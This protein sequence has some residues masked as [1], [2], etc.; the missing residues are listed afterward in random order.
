MAYLLHLECFVSFKE[1][2]VTSSLTFITNLKTYN[3]KT[4]IKLR[5]ILLVGLML[6]FRH[7]AF[8]QIPTSGMVAYYPFEGD[9]INALGSGFDATIISAEFTTN[10]EGINGSGLDFE[11]LDVTDYATTPM[12]NLGNSFSFNVWVKH[13]SLVDYG[14]ILGAADVKFGL[15][16]LSY[17]D[18]SIQA[19]LG[20]GSSWCSSTTETNYD[21]AKEGLWQMMTFTYDGEIIKLYVDG[22]LMLEHN[23]PG[24]SFNRPLIIGNRYD[25]HPAYGFDGI[26]DELRIY[27]RPLLETEIQSLANEFPI[28][29]P[30]Q[31]PLITMAGYPLDGN[32][33]DISGNGNDG[34]IFGAIP[35][36]DRYCNANMAMEFD[37]IDDYVSIPPEQI[38]TMSQGSIVGW[39]L[40]RDI[41]NNNC[42]FSIGNE[43][44]TNSKSN[45]MINPDGSVTFMLR[46][47]YSPP[48]YWHVSNP[49]MVLQDQWYHFALIQDPIFGFH[50]YLNGVELEFNIHPLGYELGT[51]FFDD[52]TTKPT[53][54]SLG[55]RKHHLYDQDYFN[56]VMDDIY[57][58]Q[59][60][61]SESEI[62]E[63]SGTGPWPAQCD[64]SPPEIIQPEE[65][66]QNTA[67]GFCY[68]NVILTEPIVY[69]DSEIASIINDAPELFQVGTTSVLWTATDVHDNSSSVVQNVTVIDN[70]KPEILAEGN[71]L[72]ENDPGTCS[73]IVAL[74]TPEVTDNCG[75]LSIENDAPVEF[76]VGLTTVTWIV[77]D[78]NENEN[79]ATTIV[80]VVNAVPVIS[81]ISAPLDPVQVNS[82]IAVSASYEDNNMESAS[83]DWGDGTVSEGIIGDEILGE[84]SYFTSGVYTVILTL[85]DIC[86]ETVSSSYQYIV[87]YDPEGG[88]V[89]GGGW[90]NSP[91]G[92]STQFPE[93]V[94]KANFGFVSKYKKGATIPTGNT[95]F[96]FKAGDLHFNSYV[97]DWLVIAGSKAKFKGEGTINGTGTYGFM[98]SAIDGDLK[99][100]GGEDKFR[101]QIWDKLDGDAV[102][103]DNQLGDAD[104]VDPTMELGGGS[105]VI[106]SSDDKKSASITDPTTRIRIYPNPFDNYIYVDLFTENNHD[107]IID[108]VDMNG[109]IVEHIYTGII[110]ANVEHQFE[111][112]ARSD[113]LPG[114]YV[115]RISNTK[116]QQLAN[117]MI[118]KK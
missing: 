58:Y 12:L 7:G 78:I 45:L 96:Q 3:M 10:L 118:I 108:M 48:T 25:L 13:E 75:V 111:M 104:D 71:I 52:F 109:R 31:N 110:A 38:R 87:V 9:G 100:I 92:V 90:I 39:F 70:E 26:I 42:I 30:P 17:L 82:E 68:A 34:N 16:L 36:T 86:G 59:R 35:T 54:A 11:E 107:I 116:G 79:T 114:T 2:L 41:S 44:T 91:A 101:I 105:I 22:M 27:S 24:L 69:D 23:C 72:L 40:I 29:E 20:S 115:L 112:N 80:E 37:G 60:A 63:M 95:E 117:K 28:P 85:T 84:H 97:Y 67:E 19:N 50:F 99:V 106:H 62:I 55:A 53:I 93:A 14:T 33:N 21:V 74:P 61:L 46:P 56:G 47:H 113:L 73:A 49:D 6:L 64:N 88:F 5:S 18:G 8:G 4:R 89:T 103:Y 66:V 81:E 77:T 43:V 57:F 102:V 76:P 83:W 98:I 94:G 15:T 1:R 32:A 65:L 51:Q